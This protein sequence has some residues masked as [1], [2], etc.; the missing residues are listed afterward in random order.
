MEPDDSLKKRE[1]SF[2]A[3]P[4]NQVILALDF[5]TGVERLDA[6][7]SANKCCIWVHYR[8]QDYTLEILEDLLTV[9]R[10]RLDNSLLQKLKRALIYYTESVQRQNMA[11]PEGGSPSRKIFAHAY[12]AHPHGDHD[13]TPEEWRHYR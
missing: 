11:A 12:E 3:L 4:P 2:C 10:F 5:L 6:F 13:E 1:I 7:P 8:L 9:Q